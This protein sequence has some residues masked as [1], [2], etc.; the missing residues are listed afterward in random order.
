MAQAMKPKD[1]KLT[2]PVPQGDPEDELP[3][4][5]LYI[6]SM[7]P[8]SEQPVPPFP[9]S[10]PPLMSPPLSRQKPPSPS[11][12]PHP[13]LAW[14]MCP[15]PLSHC[16]CLSQV[17]APQARALQMLLCEIQGPQQI[18]ADGTVQPRCSILYYQPFSTT[19]LLNWRNHTLLYSEKP[20]AMVNLLESIFQTH[21]PNWYDCQQILLIFFNTERGGKF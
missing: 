4:S 8:P 18:A 12:I 21:Q 16:L 7:P 11:N 13:S 9:D 1:Q 17:L 2:K 5:P 10:P 6:P 14:R 3:V 15:Q 19:D 20:Q